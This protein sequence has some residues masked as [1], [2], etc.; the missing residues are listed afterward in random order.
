M[1]TVGERVEEGIVAFAI[2]YIDIRTSCIITCCIY[3]FLF[4]MICARP[5]HNYCSQN[6]EEYKFQ[7]LHCFL[8]NLFIFLLLLSSRQVKESTKPCHCYGSFPQLLDLTDGDGGDQKLYLCLDY[9]AS[10]G[11]RVRTISVHMA[12]HKPA[13]PT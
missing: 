3:T 7:I 5:K 13:K 10:F 1:I 4:N 2:F 12:N 8:C 6:N 9:T 11:T